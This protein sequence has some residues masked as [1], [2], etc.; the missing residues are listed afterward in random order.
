MNNELIGLNRK[1]NTEKL[2]KLI[3]SV[4]N[5]KFRYLLT[6][7]LQFEEEKRANYEEI[8]EILSKDADHFNKY[9][10]VEKIYHN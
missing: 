2:Q 6:R 3:S 10:V 1:E 8:I 7:M 4:S 9:F 5:L